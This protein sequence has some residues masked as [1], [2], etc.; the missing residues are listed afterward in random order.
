M[1]TQRDTLAFVQFLLGLR[2]PRTAV[3]PA[4]T[5]LLR[6]LA[7][8]KRSI[9]EVGVYEGA[10]SRELCSVMCPDGLIYLVDCYRPGVRI[11]RWLGMSFARH[12]ARSMVK[13]W[14]R[15]TRFIRMDSL[16][17]A[18]AAAGHLLDQPAE[19]IFIDADH[20]YEAVR[21]DFLAWSAQLA[22]DGVLAFHDSRPCPARRDLTPSTGPVRL[23]GEIRDGRF[24]PWEVV[25]TADSV[26]AFRRGPGDRK[27]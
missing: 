2:G 16:S 21:E 22:E 15:Q 10:T 18:A 23:S 27:A 24:G 4:E 26:T 13:P 6:E 17:A 5:E 11:E 14:K 19:L 20:S 25:A 9:V 3:S 8:G 1:T 7:Q 12:V